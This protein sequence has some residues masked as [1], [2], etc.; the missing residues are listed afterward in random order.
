MW[1]EI[2]FLL[3]TIPWYFYALLGVSVLLGA[4]SFLLACRNKKITEGKPIK[5]EQ[6]DY[7]MIG[8]KTA[9]L[10]GITLAANGDIV[11]VKFKGLTGTEYR[12][13]D[14]T[15]KYGHQKFNMYSTVE[16]A[17]EHEQNWG[18]TFLEVIGFG[19]VEK[20]QLGYTSQNQRVLQ[21]AF[22]ECSRMYA[23]EIKCDN[24]PEYL[25]REHDETADGVGYKT[26]CSGCAKRFADIRLI[27][28][29]YNRSFTLT[30]GHT[31]IVAGRST[32]KNVEF[33]PTVLSDEAKAEHESDSTA[34]EA[35]GADSE[36]SEST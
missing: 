16:K 11:D 19:N 9:N 17:L 20:H 27:A 30:D 5:R 2:S 29:Y 28:P 13:K 24:E 32:R 34:E 18:S 21:M 1:S 6:V 7:P 10:A 22:L 26:Y 23:N 33:M 36:N 3:S 4:T 14:A 35:S 8:Y 25:A 15:K 31:I 12:V